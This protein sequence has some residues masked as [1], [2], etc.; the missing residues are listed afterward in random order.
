M[1]ALRNW[2]VL[3]RPQ[4]YSHDGPDLRAKVEDPAPASL[5]TRSWPAATTR[6]SPTRPS[7]PGCARWAVQ[8][9]RAFVDEFVDAVGCSGVT[10]T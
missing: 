9:A 5:R 6:G 8:T 7:V 2:S 10:G 1:I 3:Y 4:S